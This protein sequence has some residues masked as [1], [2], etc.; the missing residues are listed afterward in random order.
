ME[1]GHLEEFSMLVSLLNSLLL[2]EEFIQRSGFTSEPPIVAAATFPK[3]LKKFGP[4]LL[5]LFALLCYVFGLFEASFSCY[6]GFRL[7]L[8]ML[9]TIRLSQFYDVLSL[10][11]KVGFSVSILSEVS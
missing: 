8:C 11:F 1:S 10:K 7:G 6:S 4:S 5:N 9:W 3:F 2:Q